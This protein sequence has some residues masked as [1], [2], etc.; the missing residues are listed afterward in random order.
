[1]IIPVVLAGGSGT[2]LWPMSRQMF[3]KQLLRLTQSR[4]MLQQ[5]LLRVAGIENSAPALLICNRE[6]RYP[7]AEQ[8]KE[9]GNC[10]EPEMILE[11]A[12]RNTA[13]A[14]TVAAIR[15]LCKDPEAR[16]LVLP[17][18]HLITDNDAF[19]N[20]VYA[21]DFYAA[22]GY[23]I[24]FGVIPDSPET[25]YGYIRKGAALDSAEGGQSSPEAY[26]IE[27]F[28]E[29]PDLKTAE[30]YVASGSFCWNSGMF[31]FKAKDVYEELKRFAPGIVSAARRAW[32]QGVVEQGAMCLDREAFKGCPSDSIDYAVME[33][34]KKGAMI[35]FQAGW[36]DLGSWAAMW[37]AG[38][39]DGD[40]NVIKGE[41]IARVMKNSLVF[42]DHRL[43]AVLGMEDG[44]VVDTRD[45]L[46]VAGRSFAQEV[47]S[48]VSALKQ[49]GR[50][51]ALCHEHSYMVWGWEARIAENK[52]HVIRRL[53]IKPSALM[54]HTC[55]EGRKLHWTV[56]S[57]TGRMEQNGSAF[58]VQK[59]V[60]IEVAPQ[61][62]VK[63]ENT[64]KEVLEIIEVG[65]C[66]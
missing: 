14:V 27:E 34:T 3:P 65:F 20:A 35:P 10:L 2:R 9:L 45:A 24:T 12:G 53:N 1:M 22:R 33:K 39:K 61:G 15:A 50:K 58:D 41:V 30:K 32:E 7:I 66:A 59:G 63:L 31:M 44:I 25:G 19:R 57:G 4:T 54:E 47:K 21:A 18:D 29:K 46:L 6:H 52:N 36:S 28:V 38:E 5:T 37:E 16:I 55:P 64:G 49:D 11:P 51:E 8:I 26:A 60:V 13:P 48:V 42:S 40:G 62:P 17:A 23:L 43:V 56:I